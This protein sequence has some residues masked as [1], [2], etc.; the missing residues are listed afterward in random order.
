MLPGPAKRSRKNH[1]LWRSSEAQAPAS[2]HGAYERCLSTISCRNFSQAIGQRFRIRHKATK[3]QAVKSVA[4]KSVWW[5]RVKVF[6]VFITSFWMLQKFDF[7]G[8][9]RWIFDG[10]QSGWYWS[11]SRKHFQFY[12]TESQP[13]FYLNM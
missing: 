9:I 12:T 5:F 6:I 13:I 11:Y 7:N 2:A 3:P 4:Q 8:W 1:S 10:D